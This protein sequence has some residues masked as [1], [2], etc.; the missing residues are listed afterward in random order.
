M[1]Q[2]LPIS[3]RHLSLPLKDL[4]ELEKPER[5]VQCE[6]ARRVMVILEL[7]IF[8]LLDFYLFILR[9]ER[10][11]FNTHLPGECCF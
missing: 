5:I 4:T 1:R 6:D 11:S 8:I 3:T 7:F 9:K 10:F 2:Q